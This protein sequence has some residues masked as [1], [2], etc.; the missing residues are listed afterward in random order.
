MSLTIP[1]F[2]LHYGDS[3]REFLKNGLDKILNEAY[4]TNHTFVRS[5]EE[6]FSRW[7]SSR[8]SAAVSNGT[9]A[10][11]AVLRAC[12]VEGK[13]VIIPSNTF[14]ACAAAV[15]NA[16]AL[17]VL[18][19]IELDYLS[20]DPY[21][22]A[23]KISANTAAVLVVHIGGLISP[24][25]LLLKKLCEEKGVPL[26]ED[27]AHAH[28]ASFKGVKAGSFGKAGA[29]SFHMTKVMTTG[30]GGLVVTNDEALLKDVQSIRQFG[31]SEHN[32]SMHERDGSNFKMTEMQALM[33][34]LELQ[35][36]EKRIKK[37]QQISAVYDEKLKG[38]S[39]QTWSAAS[40][41]VCPYYKKII[42]SPVQR[43]K[44]EAT[45]QQHGISLTGG[46]YYIPVHK[47]D[48]FKNTY[49]AAEFKNTEIF[50]AE[51]ICP[52]CYPELELV[53]A[54]KICDVLLSI[55]K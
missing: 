3:D 38:S 30:E 1:I 41:A 27:C 51:H 26:I 8:F 47:Q 55:A 33:G 23:E 28:G 36:V 29:F 49:S 43:N 17:P 25:V 52:P 15:K 18:C 7:N 39:W 53:E 9:T 19:D 4:L 16:G 35:R 44:V 24:S 21:K 31:K 14:I 20:I 48:V 10:I 34:L 50:C 22:V 13:E 37:R 54:E 5:F 32:A 46:V 40:E 11:E 45:L 12:N 6:Q 2:K 42:R